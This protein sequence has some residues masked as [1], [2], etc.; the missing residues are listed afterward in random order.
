MSRPHRIVQKMLSYDMPVKS[1]QELQHW[2]CEQD[3]SDI[4]NIEIYPDPQVEGTFAVRIFKKNYQFDLLWNH[5][6]YDEV[7]FSE[8]PPISENIKFI[9]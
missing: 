9:L 5:G 8:F 2:Y 3:F 6:G 7:E 4:K 1:I